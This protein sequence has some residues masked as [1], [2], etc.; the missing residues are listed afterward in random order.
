MQN[1]SQCNMHYIPYKEIVK[2]KKIEYY[3]HNK[4]IV[5]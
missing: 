3:H 1:N 5:K 2:Q 4:E